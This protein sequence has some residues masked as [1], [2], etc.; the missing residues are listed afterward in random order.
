[1]DMKDLC[2]Y[3]NKSTAFGSG[4]FVNRLPVF[5]DEIEGYGCAECM[6]LECDRCED[7]IPLDEDYVLDEC[8]P[9]DG[10]YRVH[11]HCLHDKEKAFFEL[12]EISDEQAQKTYV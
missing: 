11:E 2:V 4:L 7:L 5:E 9:L 12:Q 1:M 3:C 6:Q 8:S 10:A